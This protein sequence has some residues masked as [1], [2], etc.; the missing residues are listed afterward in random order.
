MDAFRKDYLVFTSAG[1]NARVHLWKKG[2]EPDFDVCIVNYSSVPGLHKSEADIYYQSKGSKLGNLQWVCRINPD[3]L[4]SYSAIWVADDDIVIDAASINRLFALH[5][6]KRLTLLQPAFSL[7]GKISHPITR[8]Q[9]FTSIRY[10]N[11]VEITCPV[12]EPHFMQ[13]FLE[14]YDPALVGFGIDWWMLNLLGPGDKVA[15]SDIITC[16]NPFDIYK[17]DGQREILRL[18]SN[19]QRIKTWMAIKQ[20]YQLQQFEK[21]ELGCEYK[22]A[23][24]LLYSLP[25]FVYDYLVGGSLRLLKKTGWVRGLQ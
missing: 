24:A 15:I 18:Q 22:N 19:E 8:R 9:L 23:L 21:Q 2:A 7:R 17:K 5:R 20:K 4:N 12:V 14:V 6:E 11:F 10:T 3:L 16:V 13:R 25:G 1:E